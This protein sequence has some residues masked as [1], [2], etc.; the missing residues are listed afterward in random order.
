[1]LTVPS[2]FEP[3]LCRALIEHYEKVGGSPSGF[4]RQ[5]GEKTVG[6]HDPNFKRRRDVIIDNEDMQQAIRNRVRDRL[7][8][9]IERAFGWKPTRIERYIIACY[10]ADEQGFFRQHRDNTS[11]ATAHR[12]FAVSINL[13]GNFTGGDLRFPEFGSRT[14]RPPPG[15]ATVFACGLLHEATPVT[16]GRRYAVL[17]FL[18][19]DEAAVIRAATKSLIVDAPAPAPASS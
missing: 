4:M 13:N 18:Y 10:S 5:A 2:I 16:E 11:A 9:M 19:D 3:A 14:Y 1:V 7:G 17:P 15:G 8:P 12:K 6:R